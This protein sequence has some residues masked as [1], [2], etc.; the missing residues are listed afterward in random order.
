MVEEVIERNVFLKYLIS[1]LFYLDLNNAQMLETRTV[2]F[3][4]LQ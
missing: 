2:S 1:I 4:I 3:L